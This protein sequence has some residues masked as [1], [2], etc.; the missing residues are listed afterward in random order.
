MIVMHQGISLVSGRQIWGYAVCIDNKYYIFRHDGARV[1]VKPS[2]IKPL[3]DCLIDVRE[4]I[5]FSE[6]QGKHSLY[7]LELSEKML[8]NII[9]K[10]VVYLEDLQYWT[11]EDYEDVPGLG[12][13]KKR[14][15]KETLA[16]YKIGCCSMN[17]KIP[18]I[19]NNKNE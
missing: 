15:I 7:H 16:H 14:L 5:G 1:Q 4:K 18:L 3:E 11:D 10:G 12:P 2:S 8:Q 13:K 19:D 17:D 6:E 9:N